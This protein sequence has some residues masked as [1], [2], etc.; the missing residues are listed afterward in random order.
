MINLRRLMFGV[1]PPVVVSDFVI[2]ALSFTT[3]YEGTADYAGLADRLFGTIR[4][5]GWRADVVWLFCSTL[6][7]LLAF[8][9]ALPRFRAKAAGRR[10]VLI[11]GAWLIGAVV[12]VVHLL[13]SG[14]LYMG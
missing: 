1:L 13:H 11:A 3:W 5:S 4:F 2:L 6:F 14:L 7:V 12:Y 10:T 9:I 8:A